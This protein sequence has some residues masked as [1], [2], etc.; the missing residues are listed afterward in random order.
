M[1][2][3]PLAPLLQEAPACSRW[4][5]PSLG[6]GIKGFDA[7]AAAEAVLVFAAASH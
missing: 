5:G 3:I 6:G 4:W 1:G 2:D 7:S